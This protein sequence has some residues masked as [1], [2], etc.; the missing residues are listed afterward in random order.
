MTP[1]C[2]SIAP[3]STLFGVLASQANWSSWEILICSAFGFSGSAQFSLL[4]LVS[5]GLDFLTMLV[6][7]LSINCRY[8]PIAFA[9]SSRLPRQPMQRAFMAH[10]I[11]DESYALE[12]EKDTIAT[13]FTMR[14]SIYITWVLGTLLGTL[15]GQALPHA[16]FSNTINFGFPASMVL[17]ALSLSQIK[18]RTPSFSASLNKKLLE[19][20]FCIVIALLLLATLGPTWFWLP[21]IIFST[22]RLWR[23]SQ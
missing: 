13:V 1:A 23:I 14:F 12:R 6:V 5:N 2:L 7:A 11:G 4:P 9:T 3:I 15:L 19:I 10:I 8:I 21:S 22:W 18:L 17:L 16:W 20:V